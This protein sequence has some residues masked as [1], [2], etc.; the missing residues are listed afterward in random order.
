[1]NKSYVVALSLLSLLYA[2]VG[3]AQPA[4][5]RD[6][7]RNNEVVVAPVNQAT[8]ETTKK[9][10]DERPREKRRVERLDRGLVCVRAQDGVYCSWRQLGTEPYDVQFRLFRNDQQIVDDDF[11]SSNFLDRDGSL[12]SVYRVETYY[13]G[14]LID[15]SKDARVLP[16]QYVEIRAQRP[17]DWI[18]DREPNAKPLR[19][20]LGNMSTGDLDGDGAYEIVSLWEANSK[21]NAH[22]GFT[23]PLWVVAH[24]LD[25][26]EL[27]RFTLGINV[28]TG[29]H[30]NPFLVYD[31][32]GDG[33]AEIALKTAPGSKDAKGRFVSDVARDESIQNCRNDADYRAPNGKPLAG[34]EF[35]TVFSG[36]TGEAL[37]TVFYWPPRGDNL[38]AVWG[39]DYGNRVDRFLACVAFLDGVRPYAVFAR[40]YYTRTT[41]AAYRFENGRLE[42]SK[43][44]DS[45]DRDAPQNASYRGRG[46][47][48]I[49]V[50]DVD[51][52]GKDEIIYGASLF[53]DD[54]T[55]VYPCAPGFPRLYHGDA[56]HLGDLVP[57]RPGLEIFSVHESGENAFDMR[58]ARTG[59][60]LWYLP[61]QGRDVGRGASDDVDPRYRGAESWAS[62]KYVAA[63]GTE[64]K[65]PRLPVNFFCYWD[66]DLGR[67]PQD[68][69]SIFK[70]NPET[71]DVE[72][73][74]V[75]EQC[76][77][78]GG[79]KATPFLNADLFG[80][81]REETVYA[82]ADGSGFRVYT[83]TI[84]TQF[85]IP[86]L[87]SD[88]TYRLG[89]AWQNVGYN[90]P[91]HLGYY[92]G[93]DTTDIP[94]PLV[95]AL[96]EKGERVE[97]KWETSENIP[98][99]E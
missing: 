40:G 99:R 55:G 81:W 77:Q 58:D 7:S 5:Q 84:P 72:K 42:L 34:P 69:T 48:S 44:F 13:R 57:D 47:H 36:E 95:Y 26:K 32:D 66:G 97:N 41:L 45:D 63:D 90:Q 31:F 1:M 15:K 3:A 98:L 94:R 22:D 43:T 4:N 51:F 28:R 87:M 29:A 91:P 85:R 27:W 78:Y 16:N 52:D 65:P 93:F 24:K 64:K 14:E 56:Q 21:D 20:Q 82:L 30:Y 62:G 33:K 54:L 68:G 50:A 11:H 19:Y 71:N 60:L 9:L 18:N 25:G 92:L 39:D 75:A 38:K 96:D 86:T 59:E 70:L 46:N 17:D 35:L 10:I 49:G 83:T 12:D 8:L 79:T 2:S 80:D 76:V 74:F 67:E 23:A 6:R 61:F 89:V 73:I 37:D 53:D 88:P